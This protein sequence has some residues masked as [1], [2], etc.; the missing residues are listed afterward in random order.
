MWVEKTAFVR[1]SVLLRC[2]VLVVY[3]LL[4]SIQKMA[5]L[6][7]I[8]FNYQSKFVFAISGGD[9]SFIIYLVLGWIFHEYRNLIMR[10]KMMH[11]VLAA[12]ACLVFL[13]FCAYFSNSH[14]DT[15]EPGLSFI[16]IVACAFSVFVLVGRLFT[17]RHFSR[18]T[19]SIL[20]IISKYSFGMYVLHYF[21]M[22]IFVKYS[23][24]P[25]AGWRLFVA[26]FIIEFVSSA[27]LTAVLSR[28]PVVSRYLLLLK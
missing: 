14:G 5:A 20:Q 21:V 16:A 4:P 24:L 27:F 2:G 25:V 23:I 8:S 12:I 3:S 15:F 13:S 11:L 18:R 19:I 6:F 10:L 7:G 26:I 22:E 17:D 28:I 9:F 1:Y